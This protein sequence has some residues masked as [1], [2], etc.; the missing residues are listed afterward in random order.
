MLDEIGEMPCCCQTK[1]LRVLQEREYRPIGAIARQ[2]DFRLSCAT[3]VDPDAALRDGR[4]RDDLVFP[5]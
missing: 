3:N 5:H 4:L 2:V 1:L